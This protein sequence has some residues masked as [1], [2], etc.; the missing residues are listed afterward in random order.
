M[1]TPLKKVA[2]ALN[3]ILLLL[4]IPWAI[5]AVTSG[6]T[7]PRSGLS[8]MALLVLPGLNLGLLAAKPDTNSSLQASIFYQV[9]RFFNL[10]FNAFIAFF[11]S[12]FIARAI[13]YALAH[14]V[15]EWNFSLGSFHT[16]PLYAMALLASCV[17]LTCTY[18][19]DTS[20]GFSFVLAALFS[21]V[22]FG[23]LLV[24]HAF[25]FG[26][27]APVL[28]LIGITHTHKEFEV[29]LGGII[30]SVIS[31]TVILNIACIFLR[32]V[33]WPKAIF[34]LNFTS[35]LL[36]IQG[37]WV[38]CSFARCQ[39]ETVAG[40][41]EKEQFVLLSLACGLML[42]SQRS[43]FWSTLSLKWK[44]ALVA[45]L[46]A[47]ICLSVP[48]NAA[49]HNNRQEALQR[50]KEKTEAN[51]N[52]T[53]LFQHAAGVR[54]AVTNM[55][56]KGVDLAK[57]DFSSRTDT[58]YNPSSPYAIF[59]PE[60]FGESGA[61]QIPPTLFDGIPHYVINEANRISGVGTDAPEILFI[62]WPIKENMCAQINSGLNDGAMNY[63][64]KDL[65]NLTPVTAKA[66]QVITNLP[67]IKIKPLGYNAGGPYF[68][69]MRDNEGVWYFF[70]S[71][72]VQ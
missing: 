22:T 38:F 46:I 26:L 50:A 47:A 55:L 19:S 30:S 70:Y 17:A 16:F 28:V 51:L 8:M 2:V 33:K 66:A 44:S 10:A 71:I 53:R 14:P 18:A 67:Y 62:A 3:V 34:W 56:Q 36:A 59:G 31:L 45:S 35:L 9:V 42:F 61:I 58:A 60:Q 64:L 52:V 29:F 24:L 23:S 57:L 20:R 49:R 5:S 40:G 72:V 37:K 68:A 21:L 63:V 25:I 41:L 12:V 13:N 65:P 11:L 39:G 7:G 69:C 15:S 1:D 4:V 32:K 6:A 48:M 54:T 27:V 43:L